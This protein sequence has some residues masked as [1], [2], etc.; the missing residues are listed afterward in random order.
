VIQVFRVLKTATLA[1]LDVCCV[2][3]NSFPCSELLLCTQE[4]P[5]VCV[6]LNCCSP[7]VFVKPEC[8]GQTTC[9]FVL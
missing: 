1:G 7:S 9:S 3:G 5:I 6:P 2:E 8:S 4:E